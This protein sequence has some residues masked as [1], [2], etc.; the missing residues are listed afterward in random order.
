MQLIRSKDNKLSNNDLKTVEVVFNSGGYFSQEHM[1][2]LFDNLSNQ[3]NWERLKKLVD[4]N[5]FKEHLL[6]S[7]RPNEPI[8]YQVRYSA[9]KLMKNPDSH[10]RK[11][12]NKSYIKRALIKGLFVVET[13]KELYDHILFNNDEK[14]DLF[15]SKGYK[16][17]SLPTK[18]NY[19]KRTEKN[20]LMIHIE[21]LIIDLG[22]IDKKPNF[23]KD[24]TG[25]LVVYIDKERPASIKAQ[26]NILLENYKLL[27]EAGK[28]NISFLIVTDNDKRADLYETIGDIEIH[29]IFNFNTEKINNLPES[30]DNKLVKTY[31]GIIKKYLELQG[32]NDETERILDNFNNGVLKKDI[33]KQLSQKKIESLESL[34]D[35]IIMK[36]NNKPITFLQNEV[37][38]MVNT[39]GEKGFNRAISLLK[40]IIELNY[41]N[42]I[43]FSSSDN[44]VS[45]IY[46][47]FVT[48]TVKNKYYTF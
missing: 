38:D 6:D 28:E 14:Q 13:Y 5:Y 20:D 34:H 15:L 43:K 27:V 10:F 24:D 21:E 25:I 1:N 19:N 40:Q 12:H 37:I 3:S 22:T 31:V 26:V 2:V 8:I 45:N 47:T 35:N 29:N 23:I 11:K 46:P 44:I 33:E 36:Y 32:K 48:Y 16:L 42:Y 4:L 17:S 9:C 39:H 18:S 7:N 30:I 41:F